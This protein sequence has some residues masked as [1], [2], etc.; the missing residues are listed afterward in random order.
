MKATAEST[1]DRLYGFLVEEEDARVCKD[2]PEEACTDVPGNFF[3]I[4]ASLTLSK[5][6][7]ELANAKTVLPW[8]LGSMGAPASFL[9]F[10][11][12]VRE[13]GSLLPQLIIASAVRRHATRKRVWMAGS[14]IQAMALMGMAASALT[15]KGWRAG[16]SILGLLGIFSLARGLNSVSSKDVIGKTVPKTRRG[17]LTGFTTSVSGVLT[18]GLGSLLAITVKGDPTAAVLA[19]ILAVGALLWLGAAGILATIREVPG[20][21]EGGGR[22]LAE[23]FS[24]LSLLRNDRAFRRFVWVRSLLVST[25]LAGPFYVT[26]ARKYTSGGDLLAMFILASGL[27]RALSSAVWGRFSDRS[28]RNV[29]VAAGGAASALGLLAAILD[30]AGVVATF[31]WIAPAGFFLLSIAHSGVRIGRKTYLLDLGSGERRTDYVAVS[32]TVIGGVL[33]LGGALGLLAPLVGPGGMLF[34][35][36]MLGFIGILGGRGLPET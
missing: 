20:A 12:P 32:N 35:L 31:A 29:L 24:K 26:L 8:L 5:L 36:S 7:D 28:S 6:A 10:L 4:G 14:V 16:A 11:V 25:A 23:A 15:L 13:S 33:V 34:I 1:V 2:I 30:W 21:T 22:A 17:R 3:K 27:A 9:G 19:L 18:L